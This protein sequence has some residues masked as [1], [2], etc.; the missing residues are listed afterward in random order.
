VEVPSQ[1]EFHQRIA[2]LPG[3]IFLKYDDN[4]I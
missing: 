3:S 4:Q 2:L 1:V